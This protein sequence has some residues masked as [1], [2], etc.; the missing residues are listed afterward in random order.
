MKQ[1]LKAALAGAA[2]LLSLVI[3]G[4]A[5]YPWRFPPLP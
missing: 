1:R 3:A 2:T 5:G 4:G